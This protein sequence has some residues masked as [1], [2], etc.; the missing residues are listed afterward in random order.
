[1]TTAVTKLPRVVGAILLLCA[2]PTHAKPTDRP[3]SRRQNPTFHGPMTPRPT[4]FLP[5]LSNLDAP[6]RINRFLAFCF[7]AAT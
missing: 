3:L 7:T 1:M 5:G 6:Y 2:R 4:N